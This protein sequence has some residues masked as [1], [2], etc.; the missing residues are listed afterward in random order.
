MLIR[1]KNSEREN[2]ERIAYHVAIV[3]G[4]VKAVRLDVENGALRAP[5]AGRHRRP[6]GFASLFRK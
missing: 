2:L 5:D 3:L 4:W 1:S 6:H